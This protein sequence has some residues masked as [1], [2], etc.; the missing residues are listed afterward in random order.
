MKTLFSPMKY[1]GVL[2]DLDFLKKA[3]KPEKFVVIDM[4]IE[5][6]KRINMIHDMKIQ[7]EPDNA[8]E[9]IRFKYYNEAIDDVLKLFYGDEESQREEINYENYR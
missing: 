1:R 6:F 2:A 8:D 9:E 4:S 3:A 7:R 5:A